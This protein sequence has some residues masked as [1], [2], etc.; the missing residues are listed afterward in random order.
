VIFLQQGVTYLEAG[1]ETLGRRAI[2]RAVKDLE[3]VIEIKLNDTSAETYRMLARSY[4]AL[5][6]EALAGKNREK[7]E[8]IGDKVAASDAEGDN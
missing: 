3:S 8:E 6:D 5:G 7:G 2:K 1:D 4:E